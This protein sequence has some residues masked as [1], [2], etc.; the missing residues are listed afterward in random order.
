MLQPTELELKPLILKHFTAPRLYARSSVSLMQACISDVMFLHCTKE[1]RAS[2][3][4]ACLSADTCPSALPMNVADTDW[5][6]YARFAEELAAAAAREILPHFR[7][8]PA[9]TTSS[10]AASIP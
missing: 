8:R 4:P 9:W 1:D 2:S 7:T 5:Q 6:E 3:L 10:T